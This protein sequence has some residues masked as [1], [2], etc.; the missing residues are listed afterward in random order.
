MFKS[1]SSDLRL[2][3]AS[4]R[5]LRIVRRRDAAVCAIFVYRS[6]Q[7]PGTVTARLFG[8]VQ[9]HIG[10]GKHG[11]CGFAESCDGQADAERDRQ[12]QSGDGKAT[13]RLFYPFCDSQSIVARGLRENKEKLVASVASEKIVG[14]KAR[15]NDFNDLLE[16]GVA[17]R[18]AGGVVDLFE[19]IDVDERDGELVAFSFGAYEFEREPLVDAAAVECAGDVVV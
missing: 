19:M 15:G 9:G 16:G 12:R 3:S 14:A 1:T 7:D 10:A 2:M 13:Y 18:V 4:L 8:V 17:C 6:Q 5:E 11:G